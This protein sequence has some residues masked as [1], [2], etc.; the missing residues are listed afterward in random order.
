MP[1]RGWGNTAA[2]RE[3]RE[4][5]ERSL[6]GRPRP[7]WEP[8]DEREVLHEL[9]VLT[10]ELEL[11]NDEL[12]Q[13]QLEL[14]ASRDHYRALFDLA[15]VGYVALDPRGVVL[16]ANRAAAELLGEARGALVG[17]ALPRYMDETNGDAL[18]LHLR[19]VL[20]AGARRATQLCLRR[21]DGTR[22]SV[23]LETIPA[24]DERGGGICRSVL[25]EL[26]RLDH[27]GPP[28]PEEGERA[29]VLLLDE[30]DTV[31]TLSRRIL[32]RAGHDAVGARTP[33]EA[34]SLLEGDPTRFD[35]VVAD[36][37][38]GGMDGAGLGRWLRERG[39][40]TRVLF[41]SGLVGGEGAPGCTPFLAKPYAPKDLLRAV[42]RALGS[43][44]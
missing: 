22:F 31:R 13:R 25:T 6:A 5:A 19:A 18:Y 8:L 41:L 37:P 26:G 9:R 36:L 40:E 15:P 28:R 27:R 4:R 10:A 21:R 29:S 20:E 3:L 34:A 32:E 14:E 23:R 11:Q 43:D 16:E 44:A 35:L 38:T 24:T 30:N 33:Q 39:V 42:Q 12:R 1:K 7:S 17:A 2:K